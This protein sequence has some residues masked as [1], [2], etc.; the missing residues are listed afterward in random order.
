MLSILECP[1]VVEYH[2]VYMK[3]QTILVVM[4]YCVLSVEDILNFC[5]EIDFTEDEIAAVSAGV[6]KALAFLVK[7]KNLSFLNSK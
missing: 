1:F 6:I 5:P 7:K 2:G 3:E 4:E